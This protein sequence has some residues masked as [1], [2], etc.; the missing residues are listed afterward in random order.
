[1][2]SPFVVPNFGHP[3][4]VMAMSPGLDPRRTAVSQGSED[5]S[6]RPMR[7]EWPINTKV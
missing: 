7:R 1:M 6:L 2:S 5:V 4:R 3:D